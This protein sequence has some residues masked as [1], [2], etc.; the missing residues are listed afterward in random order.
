[1]PLE[2][3]LERL[4]TLLFHKKLGSYRAEGASA[5][6][7]WP[8]WIARE[9][10]GVGRRRRPA[11]RTAGRLAKADLATDMVRELTELQ[12]T[13]GGIYAREERPARSGLEGDLLPLPAGRRRSRRAADA[14]AAWRRRRSRGRPSRSPTSSTR[15][16]GMFAAGERPTGSRDPFG[17]RRQAQGLLRGARRSAGADRALGARRRS[18]RWSMQAAARVRSRARRRSTTAS[19]AALFA[20]LV[21]R[22]RLR[23]RAARLRRAQRARGAAGARR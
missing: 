13:M 6:R 17:L 2:A 19:R 10:F 1:M 23:A 22:L 9:A 15:V 14:G 3:R 7:R 16:V 11:P 12:G 21:E 8:R 18:A 5:S 20:F 4:D